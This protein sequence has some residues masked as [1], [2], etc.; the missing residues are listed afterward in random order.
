MLVCAQHGE[1]VVEQDEL[2]KIS[3]HQFKGMFNSHK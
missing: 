2:M 3:K 1:N